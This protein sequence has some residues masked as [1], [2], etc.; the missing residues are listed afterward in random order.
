MS[1]PDKDAVLDEFTEAYKAANGK[2]P[3]VESSNGWYSVDGGKNLRLAQ[4][5][6]WTEEL[7]GKGASSKKKSSATKSSEAAKQPSETKET[8]AKKSTAKKST[9]SKSKTKKSVSKKSS[10]AKTSATTKD[11]GLTPAQAWR[12]RLSAENGQCRLPRGLR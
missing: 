12:Q 5:E 4:L 10:A 1:N 9:A 2:K 6:E 8:S 7:K 11:G 3:K